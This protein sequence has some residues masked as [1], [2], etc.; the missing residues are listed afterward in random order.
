MKVVSLW[1][2]LYTEEFYF[3]GISASISLSYPSEDVKMKK[4]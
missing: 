2:F 4:F 1:T 3:R